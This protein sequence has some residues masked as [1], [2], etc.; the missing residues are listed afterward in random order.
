MTKNGRRL[1]QNKNKKKKRKENV[2][3]VAS[4]I[5]YLRQ[6][7]YDDITQLKQTLAMCKLKSDCTLAINIQ[8]TLT[9]IIQE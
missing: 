9:I 4:G 2:Q 5:H 3:N 8:G 7:I 6:H 1:I